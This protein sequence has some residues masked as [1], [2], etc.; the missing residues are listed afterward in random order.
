MT[1]GPTHLLD[2][3]LQ[4]RVTLTLKDARRLTGKLVAAD[5]HMNLV[6]DD[7]DE[8]TADLTRHLGKVVLR[9]SNVVSLNAPQGGGTSS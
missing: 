4:Q 8:T 9:G 5:E 7:A 3:L 1:D 6:L 2:R